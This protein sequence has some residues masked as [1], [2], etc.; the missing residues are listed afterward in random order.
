M[1]DDLN[2][3]P[4]WRDLMEFTNGAWNTMEDEERAATIQKC[5]VHVQEKKS[6]KE[7]AERRQAWEVLCPVGYRDT[8]PEQLAKPAKFEEV[9]KWQYGPKGL[10][11]VG[12][13]RRGKT[14]SVWNLLKRLYFDEHRSIIAFTPMDLK[15]AVAKAWQDPEEA[16]SWIGELR[17]VQV[18]FI[19]DLDTIKFTEAVEETVYDIFE[20]RPMHKKPVIVTVNRSGRELAARMNTNGRGAKIVERMREYCHVINFT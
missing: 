5:K 10:L 14:R 16:E 7:E 8:I 3:E 18:L 19:D 11:L 20:S 6:Q 12:P 9:Q 2:G 13:T 17:R 4:T 1:Y 15:L